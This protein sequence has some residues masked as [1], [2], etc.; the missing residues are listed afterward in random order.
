MPLLETQVYLVTCGPI[1]T[2]VTVKNT[3]VV[4][5]GPPL[6]SFIGESFD[7]IE[8]WAERKGWDY[9]ADLVSEE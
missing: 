9:E 3:V 5:A 8:A 6:R 1:T 7:R 4:N 2:N